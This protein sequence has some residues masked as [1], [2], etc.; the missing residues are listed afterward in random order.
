MGSGLLEHRAPERWLG[1]PKGGDTFPGYLGSPPKAS[2]CSLLPFLAC[3]VGLILDLHAQSDAGVLLAYRAPK[4]HQGILAS[5]P[6]RGMSQ[7][8]QHP[9]AG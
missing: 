2:A 3:L 7:P 9:R 4:G 5:K 6:V 1:W 8:T